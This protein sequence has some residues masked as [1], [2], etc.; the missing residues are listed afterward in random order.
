METIKIAVITEDGEKISSHFGMAPFY[1]VLTAQ[2]GVVVETAMLDKPHHEHHP[3]HGH[4]GH[5]H[6]QT[7]G[8][9]Q[10]HGHGRGR[11]H[12]DDMFAPVSDCQVL[13]AGGMGEGAYRRAQAAGLKVVFVGGLIEKAAAEYLAG[14]LVSDE[15]RLHSH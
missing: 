3:D 8:M 14:T 15:R 12:H 1:K 11:D 10:G 7:I 9:G 2:D 6:L 13:L 4:D 5:A